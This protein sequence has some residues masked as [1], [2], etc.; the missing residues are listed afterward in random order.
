M[1]IPISVCIRTLNN[2]A[3]LEAC[4]DSTFANLNP[5]AVVVTYPS[6]DLFA[7]SLQSK[8]PRAYFKRYFKKVTPPRLAVNLPTEDNSGLWSFTEW[9]FNFAVEK[10]C[11]RVLKVDGDQIITVE[12]AEAFKEQ[13]A[14]AAYMGIKCLELTSPTSMTRDFTGEEPRYFDFGQYPAIAIHRIP[15]TGY[16]Y[17]GDLSNL[18]DSGGREHCWGVR[19]T[20]MKGPAMFVHYGWLN[21]TDPL[22]PTRNLEQVSYSGAHHPLVD[23]SKAFS[24]YRQ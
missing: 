18:L 19:F 17:I 3:T 15:G 1:K 21:S 10:G 12:G 14:S 2:Q 16:E 11:Q 4:L 23:L 20:L 13:Y 7:S 5:S 8:F 24:T 22:R 6:D 9:A